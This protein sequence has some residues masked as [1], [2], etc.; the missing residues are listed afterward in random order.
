M[1]PGGK[2]PDPQ[3]QLR[4]RVVFKDSNRIHVFDCVVVG[5]EDV[6]SSAASALCSELRRISM[7]PN[8][9]DVNRGNDEHRHNKDRQDLRAKSPCDLANKN[10]RHNKQRWKP[11]PK[12]LKNSKSKTTSAISIRDDVGGD[13]DDN[14]GN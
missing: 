7:D 11:T 5:V 10:C 14:N 3:V 1:Q 12:D 2:N 13:I 8:K 4:E 6:R 9:E